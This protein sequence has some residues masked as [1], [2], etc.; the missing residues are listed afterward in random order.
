M[1]GKYYK[2]Q[3]IKFEDYIETNYSIKIN[4]KIQPFVK[5]ILKKILA[6]RTTLD[7]INKNTS[8]QF[9]YLRETLSDFLQ[10]FEVPPLN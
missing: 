8:M 5:N 2:Q 3:Y 6:L 10:F 4:E 1:N 7:I 9:L